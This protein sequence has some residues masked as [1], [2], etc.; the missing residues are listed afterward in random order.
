MSTYGIQLGVPQW[1]S[2]Q[3]CSGTFGCTDTCPDF[4]IKRHDTKPPFKVALQDCAGA[5]AEGMDS[6][7]L[8]AEVSIWAK[9]KLK[10]AITVNDTYF[11]LADHAGFDQML[12]GDIII[13]DRVRR[14]EQMKVLGFDEI[15]KLVQ[16]E[17]A[18]NNTEASAWAKG[19]GMKIFRAKDSVAT[20]EKVYEDVLNIDGT[21]THDKLTGVYMVY[22]WQ[23][24][25][26]CVPG[27]FMLEFKLLEMVPPIPPNVEFTHLG[28]LS[29]SV[30]P[31]FTPSTYSL[32]DFGCI[33]G[34]DVEWVRRYPSTKEGF[35]IQ[36]I[37]SPTASY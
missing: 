12:T 17:R 30:I 28:A 6:E 37:D 27:C 29:I 18:Y 8:L 34:E 33:V 20:V 16:I 19:T 9:A 32:V 21:T 1:V 23:P 15:N 2:G 13:M 24:N 22:E 25:D 4:V 11:A 26:T 14:P 5:V 10:T 35:L 36:V 3:N 7:Y 31:S